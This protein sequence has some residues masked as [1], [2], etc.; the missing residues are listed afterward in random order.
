LRLRLSLFLGD[1]LRSRPGKFLL[2]RGNFRL[3]RYM[4]SSPVRR[5]LWWRY[6]IIP[7]VAPV[8]F[9]GNPAF[10]LRAFD[11]RIGPA[12]SLTGFADRSS[13]SAFSRR[14]LFALPRLS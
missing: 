11:A 2:L 8:L 10:R 13:A 5:R 3:R 14:R 6:L 12:F 7:V 1:Y 4:P 9:N